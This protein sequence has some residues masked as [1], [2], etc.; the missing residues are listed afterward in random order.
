LQRS[1][2]ARAREQQRGIATEVKRAR[3][4]VGLSQRRLA[5]AAGISQGTLSQIETGEIGPTLEVLSRLAA[6]LGGELSVRIYPGVG[7]PI[8]DHVQAAMLQGLLQALH[9]RWK[10]FLE[11]A[12][13]RPVRGVIDLVLHDP[14]E[15]ILIASEAQSELRRLEQQ[16]R[17]S[18]AKADALSDGGATELSEL[19]A[20][21]ERHG[22]GKAPAISRLLLLRSAQATHKVVATF[23]DLLAAAYPARHADAVAALK[24]DGA[25][26]GPALVWMDL[27]KGIGTL[28][29]VPPRG[30]RLGR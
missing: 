16:V 12:V 11:V 29:D 2:H 23:T 10:R 14:D 25:W 19:L 21:H 20:A 6:A 27:A 9:P 18:R 22:D 28:R 3:E 24:G 15:A 4:D 7:T 30:I 13:H 26:P 8:R 5:S 1:G 17:W